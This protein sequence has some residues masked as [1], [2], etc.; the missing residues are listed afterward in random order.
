MDQNCSHCYTYRERLSCNHCE[1]LQCGETVFTS[2]GHVE[3]CEEKRKI[4]FCGSQKVYI[5]RFVLELV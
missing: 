3:V 5:N 4:A 2:S 1:S